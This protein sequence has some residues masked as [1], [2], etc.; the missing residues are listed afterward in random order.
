MWRVWSLFLW[1]LCVVS[2]ALSQEDV[3]I[4]TPLTK[5]LQ[6]M[7][8]SLGVVSVEELKQTFPRAYELLVKS[9]GQPTKYDTHHVAVALWREEQGKVAYLSEY[10]VEIEV[11]SPL[12]RS[13]RKKAH[14]YPH[15]YGDNYGAWFQ[16]AEKGLYSINVYIKEPKTGRVMKVNFDYLLQ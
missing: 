6:D 7:N 13:Q 16:M 9:E 5:R 12:L 4:K 15:Q 1:I 10:E 3:L 11:R 2:L 14:K 8:V